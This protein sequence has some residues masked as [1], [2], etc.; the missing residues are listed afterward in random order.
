MIFYA[1]YQTANAWHGLGTVGKILLAF[2]VVGV[3]TLVI[4]GI[5]S[6]R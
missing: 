2:V 6:K 4:A 1:S 3:V 5:R